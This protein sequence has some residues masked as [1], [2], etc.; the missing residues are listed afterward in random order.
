MSN[1]KPEGHGKPD[2][3]PDHH[4]TI[5]IHIDDN[6]RN[7]SKPVMTGD[8]LRVLGPVAGNRTL[9]QVVPGG[10]DNLVDNTEAIELKNGM[11][12]YSVATTV[13]EG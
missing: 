4:D 12:F 5:V 3:K 13:G 7:A 9:W 6:K 10:E 2:P 8:E 11:H 1:D